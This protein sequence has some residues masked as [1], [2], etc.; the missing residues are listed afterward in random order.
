MKLNKKQKGILFLILSALSFASMNMFIQLAGDVPFIQKSLFRNLIAMLF[1]L[2]IILKNGGDFSFRKENLK[3][4]ILRS[5]FGTMG[6]FMNFYAVENMLLAD[7]S[8]IGK[9]APFFVII[10]SF[11]ILKEKIQLWQAGGVI[12]AFIGSVFI[13]NPTIF[14]SVIT[15]E[16]L[17]TSMMSGAAII[18]LL[19]AMAAGAAYTLVR[20]LSIRGERG[21]FIIFFFSAF[22]TLVCLPFVIMNYEPMTGQQWLCVLGIGLSA[23]GGQFG[24]TAAYSNAAAKDISVFDYTQVLFAAILGFFV[25]GQVPSAYSIIGYLFI[26]SAAIY[27]FWRGKEK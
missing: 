6:I 2:I 23:S 10:F 13:V 18:G 14:T 16:A 3:Y 5:I 7:A 15:G 27:I 8:L 17:D 26:I 21:P 4:L 19:G 22:S 1:A 20:L 11:I 12:C 24:V 25:F 9:M